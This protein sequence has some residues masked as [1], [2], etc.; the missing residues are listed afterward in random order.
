ML[1]A[2]AALDRAREIDPGARLAG[3]VVLPRA[4]RPYAGVVA[5]AMTLPP[6]P[7]ED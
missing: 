4:G 6:V 7:A 2:P 5:I 1:D 3:T